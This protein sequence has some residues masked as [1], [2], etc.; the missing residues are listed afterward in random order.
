MSQRR[1]VA[2]CCASDWR[3]LRRAV[4]PARRATLERTKLGL[5]GPTGQASAASARARIGRDLNQRRA[6]MDA[7]IVADT[8]LEL[9]NLLG[10]HGCA[11]SID[12]ACRILKTDDLERSDRTARW[13]RFL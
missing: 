5:G 8:R 1:I 10:R 4:G 12:T 7:A 6:T 3:D 11:L 2:S 9:E 13:L